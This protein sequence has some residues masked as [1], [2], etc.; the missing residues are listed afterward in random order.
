M[1][2]NYRWS[3]RKDESLPTMAYLTLLR[4][5]IAKKRNEPLSCV[6][7]IESGLFGSNDRFRHSESGIVIS[8]HLGKH[9][10]GL[11][12]HFSAMK[13]IVTKTASAEK[14]G[15][16]DGVKTKGWC[17]EF[18]WRIIISSRIIC[19]V[20]TMDAWRFCCFR[21]WFQTKIEKQRL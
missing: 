2:I 7:S 6:I 9:V 17:I 18:R 5:S 13:C 11:F 10:A 3:P 12:R 15:T 4:I 16:S 21:E 19:G 14:F 20:I 1:L 8:N